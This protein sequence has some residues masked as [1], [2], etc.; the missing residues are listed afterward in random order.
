M[1]RAIAVRAAAL[2]RQPRAGTLSTTA[3]RAVRDLLEAA[4]DA[5][6]VVHLELTDSRV[7]SVLLEALRRRGR[8]DVLHVTDLERLESRVL[9]L[10]EIA[11]ADLDE[12]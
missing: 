4:T 8:D 2:R 6:R 11:A 5:E 9:K 3:P 7:R 12:P 1:R 10:S